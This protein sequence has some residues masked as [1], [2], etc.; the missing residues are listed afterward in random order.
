[1]KRFAL[2][3]AA[4]GIALLASAMSAQAQ[5]ASVLKPVRLGV[6]LGGTLA[7]G[8]FGKAVN[9]G[10][11]A[12]GTL[13]LQPVGLPVGSALTQDS[14]SSPS[15]EAGAMPTSSASREMG[16]FRFRVDPSWRRI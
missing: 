7:Q 3:S 11:N 5:A 4:I 1:M 14:I 2:S 12:T 6:A 15:R 16:G 9:T 13:A 8:D 10:Y